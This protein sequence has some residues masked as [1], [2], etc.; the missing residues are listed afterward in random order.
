MVWIVFE[1]TPALGNL[2]PEF[3]Q[4]EFACTCFV[5]WLCALSIQFAGNHA[6]QS[7]YR[8]FQTWREKHQLLGNPN[9]SQSGISSFQAHCIMFL[10]KSQ[11]PSWNAPLRGKSKGEKTGNLPVRQWYA[12]DSLILRTMLR[13]PQE[14]NGFAAWI[15][16]CQCLFQF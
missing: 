15:P 8:S 3:D 12:F 5:F 13:H 1:L 2:F 10:C 9:L 7:T 16:A 11:H 14:F 6:H 4:T